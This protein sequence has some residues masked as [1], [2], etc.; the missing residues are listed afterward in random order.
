[1]SYRFLCVCVY[2]L[3]VIVSLVVGTNAV[4][5]RSE[6]PT[7]AAVKECQLNCKMMLYLFRLISFLAC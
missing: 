6:L 4:D 2:L 3:F 5:S 1:M 7:T